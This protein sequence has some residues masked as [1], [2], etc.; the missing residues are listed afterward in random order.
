MIG[1]NTQGVRIMSL[2]E[3]DKLAA[4]VRVPKTEEEAIGQAALG[5]VPDAP[6]STATASPFDVPPEPPSVDVVIRLC[7]TE[8][9]A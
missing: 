6:P 3:D 9:T 8:V 5:E 7:D 4:V 1:R 2:D